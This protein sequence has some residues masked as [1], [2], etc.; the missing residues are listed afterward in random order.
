MQSNAF[1]KQRY[2]DLFSFAKKKGHMPRAAAVIKNYGFRATILHIV[3]KDSTPKEYLSRN[4]QY[5][6]KKQ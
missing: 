4:S 3:V 5:S 2:F 6:K 1:F